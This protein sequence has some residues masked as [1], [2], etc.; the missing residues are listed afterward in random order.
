M[1]VPL[2][3]IGG[4]EH[5][6]VIVDAARTRPDLW[7]VAGFVDGDE[8]QETV[9]RLGL[10]RLGADREARDLVERFPEGRFV[11][12]VG[13]ISR[14]EIREQI[15]LR[16]AQAGARWATVIHRD[17]TVS[18]TATLGEG[19]VVLAQAVVNTGACL[20]EHCVVNT[21]A[22]VE[23]DVQVADFG[24]VAP[25]AAIGGGATIGR[26]SYCGLGS[27][28][29]DH[30][31]VGDR[32]VIGMGAVVIGDVDSGTEVF[33]VPAKPRKIADA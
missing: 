26:S 9:R 31:R 8:C 12:G 13:A 15:A 11:I 4:G 6:R 3:V 25:S 7:T 30:V 27:R 24:H 28:V 10:N 5:A 1:S 21:S 16:F 2:I 17:A 22:V 20:G 19:T 23:H 32:V 29:R 18:G 14:P 33:G